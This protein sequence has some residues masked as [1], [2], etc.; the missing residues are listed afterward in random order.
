MTDQIKACDT[1]HKPDAKHNFCPLLPPIEYEPVLNE[2]E[3]GEVN[4][5]IA[6]HLSEVN[7]REN[8]VRN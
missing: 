8:G 3:L 5:A 6:A 2:I 1:G 7:E 4:E